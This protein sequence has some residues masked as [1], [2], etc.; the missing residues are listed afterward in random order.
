M[1]GF[2]WNDDDENVMGPSQEQ[3]G[4]AKETNTRSGAAHNTGE[5]RPGK[6]GKKNQNP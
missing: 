6:A 4:R 2:E 1:I 3:R 5:V